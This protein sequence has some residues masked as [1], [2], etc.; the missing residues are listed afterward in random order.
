MGALTS[1][2]ARAITALGG[3]VR[4]EADVVRIKTDTNGVRGVVLSSD[5]EL[6][7]PVVVSGAN[8]KT[9]MTE[10]LSDGVLSVELRSAYQDL[11]MTGGLGKVY[12]AFNGVP[13]FRCAESDRENELLMKA[14]FRICPKLEDVQTAYERMMG[15]DGSGVH[16][17]YGLIP[18]AFDPTLTPDGKHI[19]GLSIVYSAYHADPVQR[20]A[21]GE[22][23]VQSVLRDLRDYISN[24]DDVLEDYAYLTA[25]DM[26]QEFG[27]VG[28]NGLH[29]DI[30]VERM[31][32]QRPIAGYSDYTTP[33]RGLY[34]C[35]NGT[36]PG[37][38]LSG[39]PGHNAAHKIIADT[40]P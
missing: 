9:T 35:S 22:T 28:G 16:M 24:F 11:D 15:G 4:T 5:E 34:L 8:P 38:Y 29:G 7:A 33:V 12:L 2:M 13:R 25:G 17:V 19:M 32:D 39:M 30:L 40:A 27:L 1:A 23:W 3:E 21:E 31:F 10:L 26:E 6:D 14:G 20:R 36:W 37:M 18:S